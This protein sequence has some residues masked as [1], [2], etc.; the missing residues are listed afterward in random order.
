M[1]EACPSN[2]APEQ[3]CEPGALYGTFGPHK[4]KQV[5]KYCLKFMQWG[6]SESAVDQEPPSRFVA[7]VRELLLKMLHDPGAKQGFDQDFI[8][9]LLDQDSMSDR[10]YEILCDKVKQYTRRWARTGYGGGTP[11]LKRPTPQP[12]AAPQR[13]AFGSVTPLPDS[14]DNIPF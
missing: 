1:S 3:K 2:Q 8:N 7:D 11:P 4:V 10:Q 9:T 13:P 14:L 5:C 6:T 12:V